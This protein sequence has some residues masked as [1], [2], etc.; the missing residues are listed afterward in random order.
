[1]NEIYDYYTSDST[2]MND[3]RAFSKIPFILVTPG[4]DPSDT[5][6]PN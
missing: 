1:M 2:V 3:N 4:M 5:L 6:G